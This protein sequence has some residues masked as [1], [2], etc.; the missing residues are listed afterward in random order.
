MTAA[1]AAPPAVRA[2]VKA[3]LLLFRPSSPGGKI[4]PEIVTPLPGV[5]TGV[6]E[7][8]VLLLLSAEP[9]DAPPPPEFPPTP[10]DI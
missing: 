8:L 2:P 5:P 9:S 6:V 3:A 10:S 7:R 1:T 4:V